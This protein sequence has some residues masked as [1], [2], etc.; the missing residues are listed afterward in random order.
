MK[1]NHFTKLNDQCFSF[2]APYSNR[3]KKYIQLFH[4]LME[5]RTNLMKMCVHFQQGFSKFLL[6]LWDEGKRF[7]EFPFKSL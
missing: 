1:Y 7:S 4:T 2:F 5:I 3:K 6:G